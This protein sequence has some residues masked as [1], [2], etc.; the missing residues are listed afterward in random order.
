MLGP[1]SLFVDSWLQSEDAS[2]TYCAYQR[3][4]CLDSNLS[5]IF[6]FDF[7]LADE[8]V[9]NF[10]CERNSHAT[11]TAATPTVRHSLL[12]VLRTLHQFVCCAALDKER[13]GKACARSW[14][15]FGYRAFLTTMGIAHHSP[16]GCS[17]L[18]CWQWSTVHPN[19]PQMSV[20]TKLT[21]LSPSPR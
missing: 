5:S 7:F 3:M 14:K 8:A 21:V 12:F 6:L 4:S 16:G 10:D 15:E 20:R 18:L 13:K 17:Y 2:P 9:T 19:T 1:W 11:V